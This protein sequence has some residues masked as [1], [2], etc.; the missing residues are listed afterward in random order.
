MKRSPDELANEIVE[1]RQDLRETV[2]ALADKADVKA[3]VAET[4]RNL[5]AEA[6]G[7]AEELAELAGRAAERV[8]RNPLPLLAVAAGAAVV[9]LLVWRG[10][11]R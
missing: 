4:G 3:R 2:A 9:I 5:A 7:T 6:K 8:R 11:H 10:R 1:T